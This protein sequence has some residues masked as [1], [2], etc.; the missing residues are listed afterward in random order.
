MC[1]ETDQPAEHLA[2]RLAVTMR[3]AA[4]AVHSSVPLLISH[5]SCWHYFHNPLVLKQQLPAA[6]SNIMK[7]RLYNQIHMN[8]K[9]YRGIEH[10]NKLFW[11][12]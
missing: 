3:P 8:K 5:H 4:V 7:I 11:K 10:Q 12:D 2:L 6:M 9:N 1:P